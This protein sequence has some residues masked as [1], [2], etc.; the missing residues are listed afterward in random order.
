MRKI[1]L[2]FLLG[3][4][5][6]A[7]VQAQ[8]AKVD[9]WETAIFTSEEWRYHVGT[10]APDSNWRDRTFVDTGWS[11]AKGSFGFGYSNIETVVPTT[12]SIFIRKSFTVTDYTK[13]RAAVLLSDFD[14]SFVAYINGYEFRRVNI[15]KAWDKTKYNEV[16]DLERKAKL[17]D[18]GE[19]D[20]Y[21]FKDYQI[22]NRFRNGDNVLAIQIHASSTSPSKLAAFFNLIIGLEDARTQFSPAPAWFKPPPMFAD[23]STLPIIRFTSPRLDSIAKQDGTMEITWNGKGEKNYF[24]AAPNYY[25]GNVGIKT[26]GNSTHEFPKKSIRIETRDSAGN[27]LNVGLFGLP[28]EN[29]WVLYAPYTDKSLLRN[30]VMYN[31]AGNMLEW[32]P[33]TQLVEVMH[34]GYYLG[35]YVFM[36]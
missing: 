32:A 30:Y 33:R 10:T 11:K 2:F 34:N 18:G 13:I 15:G 21:I 19:Y 3:L 25:D 5:S 27:N 29:D 9:H 28:S 1:I 4:L 24:D 31:I 6:T 35:V 22:N 20:Y 12:R 14:A 26:R 16:G 7:F 8:Y 23:Y 17:I 36:E